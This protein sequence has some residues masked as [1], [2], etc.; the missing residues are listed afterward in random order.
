MKTSDAIKHFGDRKKLADFLGIWPQTVYQW[1]D[2]VP[3]LQGYKLQVLTNGELK[4]QDVDHD[5]P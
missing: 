5:L 2:E 4:Q 1:G 3:E